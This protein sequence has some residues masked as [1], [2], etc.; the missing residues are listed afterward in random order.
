MKSTTEQMSGPFPLPTKPEDII[1]SL[2]KRFNSGDVSNQ[3]ALYAPGAI[4]VA[5]DGR[6]VTDHEEIAAIIGRDIKL[7]LPLVTNVRHVFVAGDTAQIIV[8]W[9]I[10]G[11]G[12]DGR[13]VH[14]GG[15]ACDIARRGADGFWRY[16]IDNNQGTAVRQPA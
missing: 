6:T 8:D 15:S 3:M 2:V 1:P 11:K 10:D 7:G 9:S 5:N 12:P 16:I 4:F 14:L 13:E